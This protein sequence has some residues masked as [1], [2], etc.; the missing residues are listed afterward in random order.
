MSKTLHKIEKGAVGDIRVGDRYVIKVHRFT[1]YLLDIILRKEEIENDENYWK[2]KRKWN[3][4]LIVDELSNN[5]LDNIVVPGTIVRYMVFRKDLVHDDIINEILFGL[6]K[7]VVNTNIDAF[8]AN[9]SSSKRNVDFADLNANLGEVNWSIIDA[10]ILI[11][12]PRVTGNGLDYINANQDEISLKEF[13][14]SIMEKLYILHNNYGIIHEDAKLNNILVNEGLFIAK[15]FIIFDDNQY[16][17]KKFTGNVYLTDFEWSESLRLIRGYRVYNKTHWTENSR[18]HPIIPKIIESL[19]K[20]KYGK[21]NHGFDV[22]KFKECKN[23]KLEIKQY[24]KGITPR[25][26]AIDS[27]CLVYC[28]FNGYKILD[29][30]VQRILH[31]WLAEFRKSSIADNEKRYH[32]QIDYSS[33]EARGF[34]K[35]ILETLI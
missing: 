19:E 26:F 1:Q 6:D 21:W 3:E 35:I 4:S 18:S 22:I 34:T 32:G 7:M 16:F 10:S 28:I 20:Y 17:F 13:F 29:P 8:L 9:Y 25:C 33:T 24:I 27:L 14:L 11:I 23:K 5:L 31:H 2:E 15:R 12:S 30:S